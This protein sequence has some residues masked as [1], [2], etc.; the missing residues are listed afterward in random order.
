MATDSRLIQTLFLPSGFTQSKIIS[1]REAKFSPK[2]Y[3]FPLGALTFSEVPYLIYS[4]TETL[5]F[6]LWP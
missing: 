1:P 4:L 3:L 5:R 6:V 2:F